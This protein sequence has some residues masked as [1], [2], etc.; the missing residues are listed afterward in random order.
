MYELLYRLGLYRL[1]AILHSIFTFKGCGYKTCEKDK[2]GV[3]ISYKFIN[4]NTKKQ[5][6]SLHCGICNSKFY[7]STKK[8]K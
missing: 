3:Y 2:A 6:Y 8:V 4:P 1:P 7:D 5:E